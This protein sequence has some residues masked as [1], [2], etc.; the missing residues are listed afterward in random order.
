MLP[1]D[2]WFIVFQILDEQNER[3]DL[4]RLQLVCQDFYHI[5]KDIVNKR[6]Q[7]SSF[8]KLLIFFHCNLINYFALGVS[9]QSNEIKFEKYFDCVG[10]N[11]WMTCDLVYLNDY[12][13]TNKS[14][15]WNIIFKV[16]RCLGLNENENHSSLKS[17]E[18]PQDL[19][20]AEYFNK[21]LFLLDIPLR[22]KMN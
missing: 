10:Q 3:L 14:H 18:I 21:I 17:Y 22:P 12:I 19:K 9:N 6:V 20:S 15:R 4:L 1:L 11:V 16:I 8:R 2:I 7:S 13:I 5:T